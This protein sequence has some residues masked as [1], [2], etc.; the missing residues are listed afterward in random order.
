LLGSPYNQSHSFL[1]K[2]VFFQTFIFG[3]FLLF[4]LHLFLYKKGS[5]KFPLIYPILFFYGYSLLSSIFSQYKY[6]SLM[7]FLKLTLFFLLYILIVNVI[8]DFKKLSLLVKTVIL[9]T[10]LVSLVGLLQVLGISFT[11]WIPAYPGRISSTFGNPNFLGGFLAITLPLSAMVY[12]GSSNK[13]KLIYLFVFLSGLTALLLTKSR[14]AIIASALSFL[15]MGII[16]LCGKFWSFPEKRRLFAFLGLMI[17]AI[18]AI[19]F[20]L[21]SGSES[22]AERFSQ[23][24]PGEGTLFIRLKIWESTWSLIRHNFIFGTGLGTFQIFFPQYSIPDFYKL[25]PIGNL[26]HAENEYLEICS[27]LGI[28]GLGFFL[29]II[30]GV[31]YKTFKFIRKRTEP[32]QRIL[33]VGLLTGITAGLVQGLV[34]VSLRW[35]GPDFFFWLTLALLM[36]LILNSERPEAKETLR[37]SSPRRFPSG[38]KIFLYFLI[39]VFTIIFGIWQITRYSAN[40]YLARAQFYM[41]SQNKVKAISELEKANKRNPYCLE[42]M[43]LLGGLNLELQRYP[44]SEYWFLKLQNLAPDYGNIHEWKGLLFQ[45]SGRFDLAEEKYKRAIRM[46]SSSMNHNLL[47]EVYASQGR[48]FRAEKEFEKGIELDSSLFLNHIDLVQLYLLQEK[49]AQAIKRAKRLLKISDIKKDERISLGVLLADTYFKLNRLDE[50]LKEV[51]LIISQKPDSIQKDK[52]ADLLQRFAWE[53]VK[54]KENLDWALIFCD[55][56][57]QLSPSE[58]EIIYNTKG[59]VYFR[60]GEYLKAQAYIKKALEIDPENEKFQRDLDIVSNA[61]KGI[62]QEIEIK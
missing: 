53:K 60:K 5:I 54:K 56:A 32:K 19:F 61:I 44:D 41:D 9:S 33:A 29:W 17:V 15:F 43:F 31:F 11:T 21:D 4:I 45:R 62:K 51:E 35:T 7:A 57:I 52:I 40:I 49:Y 38:L 46:N 18:I 42:V 47:G 34:C 14:G 36:A 6:A 2:T 16:I 12:L 10:G 50:S 25:V 27:E 26:L 13:K 48:L 3:L 8:T 22:L 30:G 28:F 1:L 37:S 23:T 24:S 20:L 58:P 59:W 55:K 39:L